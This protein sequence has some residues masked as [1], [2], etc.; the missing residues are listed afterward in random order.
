VDL[1]ERSEQAL[2][3]LS[4]VGPGDV[5][6]LE[7]LEALLIAIVVVVVVALV[8]VPLLLFGLELIVLGLLVAVG[9]VARS[10]FGR[11]WVVLATPSLEPGSALA[12]EVKDGGAP[13]S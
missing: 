12:W 7:G 4:A 11:P 1:G 3:V 10:L 5:V 2:D 8:L 9:I 6:S 13:A